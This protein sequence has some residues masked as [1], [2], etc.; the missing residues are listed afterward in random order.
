HID[1]DIRFP[2]ALPDLNNVL[3]YYND[4]NFNGLESLVK[5]VMYV[6][7]NVQ[8]PLSIHATDTSL[9]VSAG[10]TLSRNTYTWYR[11]GSSTPTVITGDSVYRPAASGSYYAT[12]ANSIVTK[13]VLTTDTVAYTAPPAKAS[14]LTVSLSPVPARNELRVSGLPAGADCRLVV[15]DTYGTVWL[16]KKSSGNATAVCDV[17]R[18]KAGMYTLAVINGNARQS[19]RFV[20]E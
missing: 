6:N 15:A 11:V 20:K 17:S 18:L 2:D 4:L 19:V 10:G 9:S 8:A 1:R 14:P 5:N 16:T 3:L 13:L 12:I 7:C